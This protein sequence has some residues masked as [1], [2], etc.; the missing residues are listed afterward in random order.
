M[1]LFLGLAICGMV[2]GCQSPVEAEVGAAS[3]HS[4]FSISDGAL[5]IKFRIEE[6]LQVRPRV[7]A[8]APDTVPAGVFVAS[9]LR[10]GSAC[11]S[12]PQL[13]G[14]VLLVF[15]AEATQ[16]ERQEA[17]DLVEGEVIGGR[18]PLAPEGEYVVRVEDDEDG[19]ILCQA[20]ETLNALPQVDYARMEIPLSLFYRTPDDGSNWTRD[21]WAV[22]PASFDPLSG[23]SVESESVCVRQ[24][25]EGTI[26]PTPLAS[27][28]P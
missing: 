24:E 9:N 23:P 5:P 18:R 2:L 7:P 8:Q 1:A 21:V 3:L 4:A 14:I 13:R 10:G 11:V 16:A 26:A 20:I 27:T 25:L 17:V 28:G 12:G 19:E 15:R 22:D 6:G